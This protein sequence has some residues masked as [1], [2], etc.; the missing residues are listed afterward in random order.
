M[1]FFAR[2]ASLLVLLAVTARSSPLNDFDAVPR[3]LS[4][5]QCSSVISVVSV[6]K[7]YQATSFC[8]SFLSIKTQ[9]TTSITS[10]DMLGIL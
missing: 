4:P 6:M 7:V 5:A 10:V 9:T 3:A 2:F 8:E 1:M